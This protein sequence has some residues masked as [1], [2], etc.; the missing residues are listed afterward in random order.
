MAYQVSTLFTLPAAPLLN[1]F[2]ASH[3]FLSKNAIQFQLLV[4][5]LS[6]VTFTTGNPVKGIYY[7]LWIDSGIFIEMK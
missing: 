5:I 4:A 1:V 7:I 3:G 2:R 6:G